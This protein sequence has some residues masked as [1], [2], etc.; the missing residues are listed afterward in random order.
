MSAASRCFLQQHIPDT[1]LW[2]HRLPLLYL[3]RRGKIWTNNTI[4]HNAKIYALEKKQLQYKHQPGFPLALLVETRANPFQCNLYLRKGGKKRDTTNIK[5]CDVSLCCIFQ[6]AR[7]QHC[8]AGYQRFRLKYT[9]NYKTTSM[10]NKYFSVFLL[11]SLK[12]PQEWLPFS[13]RNN[14][15]W[16]IPY[17]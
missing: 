3:K 10:E 8:K 16:A 9:L 5:Q 15:P 17:R 11:L 14:L 12:G 1:D 6:L 13:F 4:L 7:E 2:S